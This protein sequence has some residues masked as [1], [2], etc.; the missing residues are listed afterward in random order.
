MARS[1]REREDNLLRSI[2]CSNNNNAQSTYIPRPGIFQPPNRFQ[3]I[4]FIAPLALI[5]Q[6]SISV[7]SVPP[8]VTGM[9]FSCAMPAWPGQFLVS[10]SGGQAGAS[11]NRPCRPPTFA[12]KQTYR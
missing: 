8:Q 11:D 6:E 1:I 9:N 7:G 12:I 10:G 4:A 2:G 3:F 5:D